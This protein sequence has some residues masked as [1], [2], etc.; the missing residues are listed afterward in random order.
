MQN[1]ELI[2]LWKNTVC[3]K[4]LSLDVLNANIL[5]LGSKMHE[6][7]IIFFIEMHVCTVKWSNST[8]IYYGV[9][10]SQSSKA[11]TEVWK[12]KNIEWK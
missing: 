4:S 6:K 12:L 9:W 2:E 5:K 1:L 11:E 10:A 8:S 3:Q 7:Y